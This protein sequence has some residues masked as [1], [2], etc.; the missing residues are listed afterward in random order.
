MLGLL[1]TVRAASFHFLYA[2]Y[3]DRFLRADNPLAG[4]AEERAGLRAG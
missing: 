2:E 1:L 4:S 3:N